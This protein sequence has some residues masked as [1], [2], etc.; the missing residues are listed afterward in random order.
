MTDIEEREQRKKAIFDGMGKRGQER[1][2]KIGYETWDPFQ[3]PK[4]PRERIF[5]AAS[6][7]AGAFVREYYESVGGKEESV[8][9]HRELFELC[10][11]L[12]QE[13]SRAGVI[14]DFCAWLRKRTGEAS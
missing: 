14:V 4:D 8:A 9:L 13:D 2:L 6:V 10:L 7:K 3:E 1:I 11:G 5:G 12:L